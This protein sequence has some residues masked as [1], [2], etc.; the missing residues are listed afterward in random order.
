MGHLCFCNSYHSVAVRKPNWLD[1][2]LFI[3][4]LFRF[5]MRAEEYSNYSHFAQRCDLWCADSID[6][7]P[8]NFIKPPG[9]TNRK[10]TLVSSFT[11]KQAGGWQSYNFRPVTGRFW[12]LVVLSSHGRTYMEVAEVDFWGYSQVPL[13]EKLIAYLSVKTSS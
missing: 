6:D 8:P 3:P 12:G 9:D 7:F 2:L 5:R 4:F 11:T 13:R 10:A 1:C